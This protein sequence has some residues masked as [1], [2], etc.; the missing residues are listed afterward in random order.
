MALSVVATMVEGIR[1]FKQSSEKE[2]ST[3]PSLVASMTQVIQGGYRAF[4]IKNNSYQKLRLLGASQAR[5]EVIS[6]TM[7]IYEK[8][9]LYSLRG[10]YGDWTRSDFVL[11]GGPG[12][13]SAILSTK[14]YKELQKIRSKF[15]EINELF[16]GIKKENYHQLQGAQ[17]KSFQWLF[18]ASLWQ[19]APLEGQRSLAEIEKTLDSTI[20]PKERQ[21]WLL[22]RLING[23]AYALSQ[24]KYGWSDVCEGLHKVRKTEGTFS[25]LQQSSEVIQAVVERYSDLLGYLRDPQWLPQNEKDWG[26]TQA[27]L[28]RLR[29]V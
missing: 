17:F 1:D 14:S 8:D 9:V 26:W 11:L 24:E 5:E 13:E 29:V 18:Q 19:A 6:D 21:Q 3:A 23:V 2:Y 16:I 10:T 15:A 12:G 20:F 28:D 27:R 7:V 22:A 4:P 25:Q